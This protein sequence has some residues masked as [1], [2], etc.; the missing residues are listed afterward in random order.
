MP[1]ITRYATIEDLEQLVPLFDGYRQFYGQEPDLG[2]A[3][4]FL[5]ERFQ[6]QESVVLVAE[7]PSGNLVGFA[8][9]YPSFSSV[10]A[11]RTFVL[12][13][14]F[15]APESRRKGV[16]KA[17]LTKA[18]HAGHAL[19]AVRLSLSTAR[20]N[21]PAQSLYASQGWKRDDVFLYYTLAL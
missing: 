12:N 2:L 7:R 14:L 16:A 18:T 6:H 17:L 8:Q 15:V 13:D 20:A 9:L 19:G 1:I 4:K 10:R 21:E 3:R 11:S 5:S